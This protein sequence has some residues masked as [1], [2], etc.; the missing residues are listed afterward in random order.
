M[1]LGHQARL[2]HQLGQLALVLRA[3]EPA[4]KR[5]VSPNP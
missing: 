2:R 3:V 5:R 1:A 4:I